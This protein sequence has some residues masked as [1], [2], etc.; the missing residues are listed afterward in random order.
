MKGWY[1]ESIKY[2]SKW[3]Y[4]T[5]NLQRTLLNNRLS[6]DVFEKIQWG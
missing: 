5:K 2:K 3:I 1:I 6:K 4:S